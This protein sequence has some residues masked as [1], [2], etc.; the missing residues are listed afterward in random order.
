MKNI[1]KFSAL[2]SCLIICFAGCTPEVVDTD[3]Y[4]DDSVKFSAFSP[5]PVFRGDTLTILGSNLQ[6]IKEVLIPGIDPITDFEVIDDGKHGML[7]VQIPY[8]GPEVGTIAIVDQCGHKYSSLAELTYTEPIVI[9]SFSPAEAMPGD[10]VTVKGDYLNNVK[11]VIFAGGASVKGES[12]EVER[13]VLKFVVP[14]N[15][16]TGKFSVSDV[17][18]ENNPDNLIPNQVF[19]ETELTI[20]EPTVTSLDKETFKLGQTVTING[21]YLNMIDYVILAGSPNPV[22]I[23]EFTVSEDGK[24]LT[25][26]PTEQVIDGDVT[27]VSFAGNQYVAGQI[28]TV[29]PTN[30]AITADTRYKAGLGTTITGDDLD[31]VTSVSFAGVAADFYYADNK[32]IANVPAG[33][34]DGDVVLKLANNKTV[35]VAAVEVVKPVIKS[36]SLASVVAEKEV[37]VIGED[38]DLVTKVDISGID[39]GFT[40]VDDTKLTVTVARAAY[41]GDLTVTAA[42]GCT[43]SAPI[44]VTYDESISIEFAGSISLGGEVK[45]TG[46]N[47]LSIESISIKGV[48]VVNYTKKEDEAMSFLL[49]DEIASP[50]LYNL[51]ITLASGETLTWAVPIEVTAAFVLETIWEGSSYLNWSGMADLAW[52]GYDWSKVAPGTELVAFFELDPASDY[53]QVRFGNGSWGSLPSGLAVAPGEGN[54][55]MEAGATSYSIVLSEADLDMLVNQGGLVMTGCNYTLKKL[56][57]KTYVKPETVVWEGSRN[58]SDGSNIE[59]GSDNDW[60]INNGLQQGQ[61]IKIYFTPDDATSWWIQIFDGHWNQLIHPDKNFQFSEKTWDASLGYV[62]FEVTEEFYPMLTTIGWWGSAIILQGNVT[63]TKISFI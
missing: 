56:A 5:N 12:I 59:L 26:T 27:A 48:K 4:S 15:A 38:L 37:D 6:R 20:G 35:T 60:W 25:V 13:Y 10:I 50:G 30:T 44:E 57:F 46:K 58:G 24:K 34:A 42:N 49:P 2:L 23:R 52:G 21:A 54:I 51:D 31:L 36:L 45:M 1:F 16:L 18:P 43:S 32:I 61:K 55:P 47:L 9:E 8:D 11:E 39:C 3:Q 41:T 28:A 33:A 22:E 17:D 29:V 7:K 63:F 19:T 62:E 14:A 40:L 53:W